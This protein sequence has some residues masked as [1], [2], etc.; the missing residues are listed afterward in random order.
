MWD[1][2]VPKMSD[3]GLLD[4]IDGLMLGQYFQAWAICVVALRG[5]TDD[6]SGEVDPLVF[7]PN[8][9]TGEMKVKKHPGMTAWKDAVGVMTRIATEFGL[10]PSARARLGILSAQGGGV[11]DVEGDIGV[12]ARFLGEGQGG[13]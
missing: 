10:T 9:F 3:A 12:P 1:V 7:E 13:Q 11:E 5:M 6:D 8:D 4:R 2:E